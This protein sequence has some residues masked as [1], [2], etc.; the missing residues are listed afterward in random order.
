[1]APVPRAR[2]ACK[3][4]LALRRANY[5]RNGQQN[6]SKDGSNTCRGRARFSDHVV[7]GGSTEAH[8]LGDPGDWLAGS[9]HCVDGLGLFWRHS[10]ALP[11]FAATPFATCRQRSR[12]SR[13]LSLSAG[14]L[15]Q[16]AQT[17]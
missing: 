8:C 7:N 14:L 12:N 6:G 13:R 11:L 5:R 17:K 10:H 16:L 4:Q 1:M 9:M 2:R 15:L 3:P